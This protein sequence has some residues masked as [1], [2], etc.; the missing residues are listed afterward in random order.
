MK[1]RRSNDFRADPLVP[2]GSA[3]PE[4]Y[5]HSGYDKGH[6]APA[7]D[8]GWSEI[9][10]SE[11]FYMSNMSPQDPMCNRK[12]W[13]D[14]ENSTRE[15]A[16]REGSTFIITGPIFSTNEVKKTIGTQNKVTVP[17]AYYKIIYAENS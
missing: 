11:S 7:A 3:T 9:T 12:V 17:D 6:M 2:S 13:A 1:I 4:D 5:K 16:K 14:I 8:M 10:M 15:F